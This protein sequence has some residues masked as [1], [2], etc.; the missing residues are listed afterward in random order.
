FPVPPSSE[1]ESGGTDNEV[2]SGERNTAPVLKVRTTTLPSVL[3][4]ESAP[5]TIDYFSIDVEG[6][7]DRILVGFPFDEYVFRCMT[8]ERPKPHLRELLA[9]HRYVPVREI[10]R[11]D[12]FYVHESYLTE[13]EN[14]VFRF[15]GKNGRLR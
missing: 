13:Y 7:E 15:W 14:N 5:R 6:A 12:V 2:P 9:R 11:H 1:V 4:A 3:K 8:I 10:P